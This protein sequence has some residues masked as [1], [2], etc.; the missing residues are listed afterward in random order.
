MRQS[1]CIKPYCVPSM[2]WAPGLSSGPES[3]STPPPSPP[4]C[5]G[6][7]ELWTEV[8]FKRGKVT[9]NWCFTES[10]MYVLLSFHAVKCSIFILTNFVWERETGMNY[11]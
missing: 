4:T 8:L 7:G 9:I 5:K 10:K 1:A 6:V 2:C 11:H 3:Y